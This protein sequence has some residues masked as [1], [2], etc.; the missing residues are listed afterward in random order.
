MIKLLDILIETK[1]FELGFKRKEALD[2]VKSKADTI[3]MHC[4]KILLFPK[5]INRSHWIKEI[6]SRLGE[7]DRIRLKPESSILSADD[8][9]KHLWEGYLETPEQIAIYLGKLKQEYQAEQT[10]NAS[11]E[12]LYNFLKDLFIQKICIPLS[13]DTY[14]PL[15]DRDFKN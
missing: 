9:K 10:S 8:Y 14:K 4:L 12:V 1:L 7:L 2:K 15:V 6:N 13:T 5:S 11:P 3:C